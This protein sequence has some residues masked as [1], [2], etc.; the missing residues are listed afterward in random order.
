M[1]KLKVVLGSLFGGLLTAIFIMFL[2]WNHNSQ[3]EIHCEGVINWGYWLT[4]GVSGFVPVFLLSMLIFGLIYR[5]EKH[6]TKHSI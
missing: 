2:A 3:C 5:G 6:I 4:L 1:F